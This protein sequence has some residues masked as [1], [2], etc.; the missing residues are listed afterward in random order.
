VAGALAQSA[1][2]PAAFAFAGAAG[3]VVT[4]IAAIGSRGLNN[5]TAEPAGAA[6]RFVGGSIDH[7]PPPADRVLADEPALQG[8]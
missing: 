3:A 1:G 8:S 7:E 5:V 4:L 6:L 2:A